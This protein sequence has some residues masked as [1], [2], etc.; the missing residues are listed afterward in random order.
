[1]KITG[2]AF[3]DSLGNKNNILDANERAEVKFTLSNNGKGV[4]SDVIIDIQDLNYTKGITYDKRIALPSLAAGEQKNIV[5]PVTSKMEL[6]RGETNLRIQIHEGNG[7]DAGP[8]YIAFKT[9]EYTRPREVAAGADKST[10]GCIIGN[11]RDGRGSM[12]F[13]DGRRYDGDWNDNKFDG[14]GLMIWP[15]GRR[16]D[17]QWKNDKQNGEGSEIG[18]DGSTYL[19]DWNDGY[20]DGK[21]I[22]ISALGRKYSGQWKANK[23]NGEGLLTWPTG[24]KYLGRFKD[25]VRSGAGVMIWPLGDKYDGQWKDDKQ[26]GQGIF[27]F[28]NKQVY[29]GEWKDD[30]MNGLG[31]L[32]YPNGQKQTGE[33]KDG[34]FIKTVAYN[35][36]EKAPKP[37]SPAVLE[38]TNTGFV[39]NQGNNNNKLEVNEKGEIHFTLS[40]PGKGDAYNMIIS[41]N[42]ENGIKG[43][44]YETRETIAHLAAGMEI[45]VRFPVYS[46]NDLET[47]ETNFKIMVTEANGSDTDP[48]YANF[49]TQGKTLPTEGNSNVKN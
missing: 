25:G 17:G 11:C 29:D 24:Q 48:I 28:A 43:I 49:K 35:H 47:G 36:I 4:A 27:Y 21:G 13:R 32:T 44:I 20:K 19:G 42:D 10:G 26:N 46:K 23:Q 38:I 16:Y 7:F 12:N 45:V 37:K 18:A 30:R 40:N 5:I 39:D 9:Q 31:T 1:M 15:D 8:F 33:W 2:L 14:K 41:I 6:T 22:S 34:V 3:S